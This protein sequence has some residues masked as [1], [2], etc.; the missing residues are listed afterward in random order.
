VCAARWALSSLGQMSST[1]DS[2]REDVAGVRSDLG[3]LRK[4]VDTLPDSMGGTR[5]AAGDKGRRQNTL[6]RSAATMRNPYLAMP[7]MRP[8]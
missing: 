1:V 8:W 4:V 5:A 2:L 3:K 7:P 6:A